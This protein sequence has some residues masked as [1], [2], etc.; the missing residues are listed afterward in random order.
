M[1]Y[2][3]VPWQEVV[4][5]LKS[6]ENKGIEEKEAKKR[7]KLY[8]FN[9]IKKVKKENALKMF[10]KQFNSPLIYLLLIAAIINYI[11]SKEVKE[12]ALI[13]AI[14]LLNALI[15]YFQESNAKKTLESLKKHL[16]T[17]AKVIR[18]GKLKVIKAKYLVPGDIIVL[19]EGDKICADVRFIEVNDLEVDESILT[20]ESQG[21]SKT[22]NMLK[23]KKEIY[24]QE[25]I[26]FA[27]TYVLKGSGKAIV[28]RTGKSTEF[29]K[30]SEK[31]QK[32][33]KEKSPFIKEMENLSY[34]LTKV[35]AL[36]I[37]IIFM[38]SYLILDISIWEILL[39]TVSLAVATI[40]EGLPAIV[41]ISLAKG[42]KNMLKRNAL[43]KN[44]NVLEVF[45]STDVIAT[46]KTGTLTKNTLNVS[47]AI[48]YNEEFCKLVALYCN[49][50]KI[51]EKENKIRYEGDVLDIALRRWA[52]KYFSKQQEE[53]EIIDIIP[54]NSLSKK[55][56]VTC[57]FNGKIIELV[58]GAPEVI[59]EE[60][61]AT[62]Q[63]R[64]DY[65]MLA[66]KGE[67]VIA[68]AVKD[69]DKK[70][71]VGIIG[72]A[73]L[74]RKG[75]K[76]SIEKAYEAGMDIIMITGDS[77]ITAKYV[78]K[79]LN[80][81][82]KVAK[83]KEIKDFNTA[84]KQGIRVFARVNPDHKY[85]IIKA[86]KKQGMIVS[87]TGDGVNDVLALKYADVGIA[88]GN[89]GND[90]AKEAADIILLDDNFT[91]IV[92]AIEEGR[93]IFHNIKKSINYLISTNITE[94]TVIF[95]ATLLGFV[96]LKPIHLLWV[97]LVTDS[98]PAIS[99]SFDRPTKRLMSKK[100]KETLKQGII[101]SNDLKNMV[102]IGTFYGTIIAVLA[103]FYSH[104]SLAYMQTMTL[105][106]MVFYELARMY[107]I[108]RSYGEKLLS[109]RF[110]SASLLI[111]IM[112]QLGIIYV[113][114]L[115]NYFG[116]VIL[117]PIDLLVILVVG[118][119]A[120]L[121]STLFIRKKF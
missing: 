77:E 90:I 47:S 93:N 86:L 20:G 21:I 33:E 17:Y 69:K 34:T 40:P 35:I 25:N 8:G 37:V 18:N 115:R 84:L 38:L 22:S 56:S 12:T 68:L 102:F 112:L 75:V 62:I 119:I 58:K 111:I 36:I 71:I 101:N 53:C 43:V 105:T 2:Y 55:M 74:P 120:I 39:I 82:G 28:I 104:K 95:L 94:V 15:G 92:G 70:E 109:N 3:L 57:R 29:G 59:F 108:K 81:K 27:G 23:G 49:T 7:L 96:A 13:L 63:Q 76:E 52:E 99:F 72:L 78:A 110:M 98:L 103:W 24:E 54:F 100:F 64:R 42:T 48:C 32:I 16:V 14:V 65:E 60:F 10:L 116:L 44:L 83:A 5:K 113:P 87:M 9:E 80:I 117:H 45:G 107:T 51:I 106:A 73:D 88:M 6:D 46:D 118:M 97:N 79:M 31:V 85:E 1:E 91:N 30:I 11:V 19:E 4:K 67:R 50:I 26:G 61:P 66:K 114:V 89:R 41:T 121:P